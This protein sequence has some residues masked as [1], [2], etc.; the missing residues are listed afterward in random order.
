[1]HDP[2]DGDRQPFV[3]FII[4]LSPAPAALADY[5]G[6]PRNIREKYRD[7]NHIFG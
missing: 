6:A 7:I 4:E 2:P 3:S 1:M 5:A